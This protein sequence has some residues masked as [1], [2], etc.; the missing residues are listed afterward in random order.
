MHIMRMKRK[1]H[2]AEEKSLGTRY[3]L[4]VLPDL[5]QLAQAHGRSFN[6]EVIWALRQ[7][8]VQEKRKEA[9]HEQEEKR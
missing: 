5:K 7:Y 2:K 6:S 4:D 9:G 3:P 8:I 1:E